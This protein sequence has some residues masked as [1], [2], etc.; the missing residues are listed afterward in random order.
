MQ[1]TQQSKKPAAKKRAAKRAATPPAPQTQSR[2]I[3]EIADELEQKGR[4][5]LHAAALARGEKI[6]NRKKEYRRAR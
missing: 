3:D 1:Q 6:D 4:E 2:T 5:L